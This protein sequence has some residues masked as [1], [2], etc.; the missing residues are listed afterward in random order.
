MCTEIIAV[1]CEI[2]AVFMNKLCGKNSE[3]CDVVAN[4]TYRY[5]SGLMLENISSAPTNNFGQS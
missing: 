4:D 5:L 2:T 3:I 1:Y